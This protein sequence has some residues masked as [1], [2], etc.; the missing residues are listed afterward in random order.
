MLFDYQFVDTTTDQS[1][2]TW[3]QAVG[4]P[5]VAVPQITLV[6]DTSLCRR[7]VTAFN[8]ILAGDSLP[9]SSAVNL[10][11]YGSTRYVI[12]DPAHVVGEWAHEAVVDTSFTK[13]KIAAR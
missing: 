2:I 6:T 11:R 4:L 12:G 9:A 7:G 13:V 5:T 8:S 3:R 1:Q 10:L